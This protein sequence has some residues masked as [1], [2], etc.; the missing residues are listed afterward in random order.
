M[1]T[2]INNRGWSK[3][4]VCNSGKH[5]CGNKDFNTIQF[6]ITFNN[7]PLLNG[8]PFEVVTRSHKSKKIK[9]NTAC[10]NLKVSKSEGKIWIVRKNGEN[11]R[12]ITNLPKI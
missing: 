8:F 3:E 2:K 7:Y 5:I 1:K 6:F 4:W 11:A 10:K 9:K 12:Q